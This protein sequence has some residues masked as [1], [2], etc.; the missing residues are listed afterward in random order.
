MEHLSDTAA[1]LADSPIGPARIDPVLRPLTR[2]DALAFA[3]AAEETPCAERLALADLESLFMR[4]VDSAHWE[5]AVTDAERVAEFVRDRLP[6]D[7]EALFRAFLKDAGAEEALTP[8]ALYDAGLAA[9]DRGAAEPCLG[10]FAAVQAHGGAL[11]EGGAFALAIL[12]MALGNPLVT[13]E[14]AAGLI[15][16]DRAHPRLYLVSGQANVALG[17]VDEAK[18][19]FARAAR[20]GRRQKVFHAEQHAAQRALIGLQFGVMPKDM[21]HTG[22]ES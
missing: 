2:S 5:A 19:D 17:S 14:I 18:A 1:N 10:A 13:V 21:R 4:A 9:Y 15:A 7:T 22:P 12:A 3:G 11:G 20:L 6:L 8:A 16:R